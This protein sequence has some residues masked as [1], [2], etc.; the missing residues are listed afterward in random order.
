[1]TVS[2]RVLDFFVPGIP[3]TQGSKKI[4][5]NKRT[6]R[7]MMIE[8]RDGPL[9]KWRHDVAE[10]AHNRMGVKAVLRGDTMAILIECTFTLPRPPSLHRRVVYPNRTPDFDKLQRAVCDALTGVVY[11]DDCLIVD[12]LTRK[13]YVG[14]PQAET[15]PGVR[16]VVRVHEPD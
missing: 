13:R 14:H 1:M 10:E 4:V 7:P 11:R 8:D 16:V 15:R 2:E 6:G 5:T 9:K 3:I 12:G